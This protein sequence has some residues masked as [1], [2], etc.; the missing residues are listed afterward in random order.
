MGWF[1]DVFSLETLVPIAAGVALPGIG[2]VYS[3]SYSVLALIR[4]R[5]QTY[6]LQSSQ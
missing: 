1:S 2:L 4:V 6:L 5:F 3:N